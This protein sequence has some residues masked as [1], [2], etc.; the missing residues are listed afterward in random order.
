MVLVIALNHLKLLHIR[1]GNNTVQRIAIVKL[2]DDKSRE[3]ELGLYLILKS[4][5]L[6]AQ[7]IW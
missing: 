7:C 1:F 2:A 3:R 4:C 6:L 5:S